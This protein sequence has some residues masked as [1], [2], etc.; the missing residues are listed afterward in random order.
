MMLGPSFP[1]SDAFN[2]MMRKKKCFRFHDISPEKQ[3]EW[4][5]GHQLG[6]DGA[7]LLTCGVWLSGK[8]AGQEEI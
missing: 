3:S 2:K 8:K 7:V 1:K 4:S 5:Q 6:C